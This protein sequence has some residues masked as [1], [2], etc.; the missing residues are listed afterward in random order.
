MTSKED[1]AA[2]SRAH[3]R[4][5]RR[6]FLKG[7]GAGVSAAA[8]GSVLGPL[9]ALGGTVDL[10]AGRHKGMPL[11][12]LGRTGQ[13]VPVFGLGGGGL[14]H[15]RNQREEALRIL[16]R[17]LE[18]GVGYVDTAPQYGD[19]VSEETIGEGLEG[20]RDEGFLATK[21][22]YRGYDDAMRAVERSLRRL[23]TDVIDLYQVH[24]LRTAGETERV[25][26]DD[27]AAAAM[28]RL[29]E[30]GVVRHIGVTGHYNPEVLLTAIRRRDFDCVLIP[31]NPADV[32]YRPFQTGLLDESLE[33][34]LGVIAMK[35]VAYGRLLRE[36]GVR[37]M[38]EALGYTLSFPVSTA[39][40]AVSSIEELEE[41]VEIAREFQQL[42]REEQ[43]RLEEL[44]G[45]Y[46]RDGNFFKYE[47]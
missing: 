25:V 7:V 16:E 23:R 33:R 46:E 3:F 38:R 21:T 4:D 19:G 8:I 28:E 22:L 35:V 44:A 2:N 5:S 14:F 27:G 24:G 40:V 20:R 18:L 42:S 34:D 15:L 30:E 6:R 43:S 36:D 39:I 12:R 41:N 10:D 1:G 29:R 37:S 13:L 17:A 11:R 26:A 32:H 9:R 47:W 31:L 45:A